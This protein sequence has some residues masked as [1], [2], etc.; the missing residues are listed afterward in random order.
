M[1]RLRNWDDVNDDSAVEEEIVGGDDACFLL[2]RCKY[3]AAVSFAPPP[4]TPPFP[5]LEVLVLSPPTELTDA[6]TEAGL[7]VTVN[8]PAITREVMVEGDEDEDEDDEQ[9][10]ASKKLDKNS[11]TSPMWM[12]SLNLSASTTSIFTVPRLQ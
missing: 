8:D 3:T 12:S 6:L 2:G 4:P 11:V 1:G 5:P 9:G 7:V 10:L